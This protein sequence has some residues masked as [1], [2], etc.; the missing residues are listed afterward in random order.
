VAQRSQQELPSPAAGSAAGEEDLRDLVEV[1]VQRGHGVAGGVDELGVAEHVAEHRR[2]ALVVGVELVEGS[3]ESLLRIANRAPAG[4]IGPRVGG[5]VVARARREEVG[6]GGEVA[7]ERAALHAR[8]IGDGAHRRA[9]RPD[10]P[11]QLDRRLGDPQ[12]RLRHVLGALLQLVSALFATHD[13]VVNLARR[14]CG[15]YRR[16]FHNT[17]LCP[18][19]NR[20]HV[21][22]HARAGP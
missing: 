7:I 3:R 18:E 20:R 10:G 4:E 11:V 17:L 9:G 14:A 2:G 16:H 19:R 8:A 13:R 6:L 1:R 5:E 15:V 22:R 12:V 21:H